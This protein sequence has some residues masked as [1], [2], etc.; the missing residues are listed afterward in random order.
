MISM[1]QRAL[2][3]V[4]YKVEQQNSKIEICFFQTIHQEDDVVVENVDVIRAIVLEK[5]A[6]KPIRITNE[7]LGFSPHPE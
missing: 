1:A 7:V 2:L 3:Y 6:L 5:D 4:W